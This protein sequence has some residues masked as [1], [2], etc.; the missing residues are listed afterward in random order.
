MQGITVGA[1]WH[2]GARTSLFDE[3]TASRLVNSRASRVKCKKPIL[4]TSPAN[5]YILVVLTLQ[6]HKKRRLLGYVVPG[7]PHGAIKGLDFMQKEELSFLV[8]KKGQMQLFD[9]KKRGKPCVYRGTLDTH[10]PA[11]VLPVNTTRVFKGKKK[12]RKAMDWWKNL[13]SETRSL[14]QNIHSVQ[15]ARIT[16]DNLDEALKKAN[17]W[18]HT[19][20]YKK[21]A[22]GVSMVEAG[23]GVPCDFPEVQQ[24]LNRLISKNSSVFSTEAS[25]VGHAKGKRRSI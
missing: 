19:N 12:V 22:P 4:F 20:R 16:G 8:N 14:L 24:D 10:K 23:I 1:L 25:D 6:D 15:L 3:D 9:H 7:T 5:E 11:G 2:S 18:K 17:L 13:D 21:A